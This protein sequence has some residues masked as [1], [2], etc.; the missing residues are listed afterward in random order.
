MKNH[1]NPS[2]QKWQPR[3]LQETSLGIDGRGLRSAWDT[4]HCSEKL[5]RVSV[6]IL[7]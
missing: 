1:S 7:E 3:P 2:F 6:G 4:T 5:A